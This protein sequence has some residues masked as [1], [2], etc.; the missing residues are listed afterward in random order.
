MG[1]KEEDAPKPAVCRRQSVTLDAPPH[2]AQSPL[3]RGTWASAKARHKPDQIATIVQPNLGNFVRTLAMPKTAPLRDFP[4]GRGRGVAADV[5][6]YP[7]APHRPGC[8]RYPRHHDGGRGQMRQPTVQL[9]LCGGTVT[10][11]STTSGQQYRLGRSAEHPCGVGHPT[12][13]DD[14]AYNKSGEYR[15]I[16]GRTYCPDGTIGAS[17]WGIPNKTYDVGRSQ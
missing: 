3:H 10:T 4:A 6:G 9:R 2:P 17:I 7:G 8:G 15:R 14:R 1:G 11:S 12:A 5:R 16:R 13:A